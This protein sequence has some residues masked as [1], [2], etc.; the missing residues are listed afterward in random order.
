MQNSSHV[1]AIRLNLQWRK[2]VFNPV[3]IFCKCSN[4]AEKIAISNLSLQNI[5]RW[6]VVINKFRRFNNLWY[7]HPFIQ[8]HILSDRFLNWRKL[9]VYKFQPFDCIFINISFIIRF[10]NVLTRHSSVVHDLGNVFLCVL[11]DVDPL[12]VPVSSWVFKTLP[13]LFNQNIYS[14]RIG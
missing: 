10:Q 3:V 12:W 4:C 7:S 2:N 8:R 1:N 6:N 11:K 5:R 13:I 14:W 9:R